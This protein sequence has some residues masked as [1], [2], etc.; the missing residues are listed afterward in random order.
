MASGQ[1]LK[2]RN[3]TVNK[4]YLR[5]FADGNGLLTRVELP[6]GKRVPV[7]VRDATVIRNFYVLSLPDGTETDLAEDAFGIVEDAAAGA[8]RAIVDRKVWPIPARVREDIAGWIALQY[9]RGPW[10]RQMSREIAEEFSTIGVSVKDRDGQSIVVKMPGE[11]LAEL[12]G[13]RLQLDLI[14]RQLPVVAGMLYERNWF[15]TYYQRMRLATSDAPVVLI[16]EPGYPEFLGVGIENAAE[17]YIPLDRRVSLSITSQGTGDAH[18]A[19]VVKTALYCNDAMARNARRY[20][21]HHPDDDPLQGLHLPPPRTRELTD[22]RG[23]GP[24]IEHLFR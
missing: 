17:I 24:L 6:G 21:F 8:V 19:G 9:L 2:R 7:S 13:S 16:P 12:T 4:A 3:H 1:K 22:P 18:Q 20:L 23:A 14:R 11:G 10:V 15:L 5:R